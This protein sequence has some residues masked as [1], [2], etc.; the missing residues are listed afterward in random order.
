V[1]FVIPYV[2]CTFYDLVSFFEALRFGDV[3]VVDVTS[4]RKLLSN[5]GASTATGTDSFDFFGSVVNGM[6]GVLGDSQGVQGGDG[7]GF[8]LRGK[9]SSPD[10]LFE[11][12]LCRCKG[13]KFPHR[14]SW[15]KTLLNAGIIASQLTSDSPEI[16]DGS[17]PAL[18]SNEYRL[19]FNV[20]SHHHRL[21]E[22]M[23][24]N[25]CSQVH[26]LHR[27]EFPALTVS[28]NG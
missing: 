28:R 23:L 15:D 25:G 22:P 13:V 14:D 18:T 10:I 2:F 9:V 4:D 26:E 27:V 1:D 17:N 11:F 5:L 20:I 7:E 21:Q 8:L 3:R 6:T 12:S 16:S 19:T 24:S